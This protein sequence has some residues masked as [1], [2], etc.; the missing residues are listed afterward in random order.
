ME[1][2][3]LALCLRPGTDG[4]LACAVM[5]VLFRDGLADRDYLE[6]HTDAP[7]EFEAHLS[8][9]DPAWAS[10]ITGLTV[11]E[12]ETFARLVGE[13]KRTF[14]RL[15]YGF[16]RQRNGAVNMHAATCIAAVTGAWK[17]EGGGAF[18]NN[19]GIYKW[20]QTF[21]EGHDVRDRSVRVLDQCHIGRI[22]TGDA[23]SLDYGP[24]VTAMLIQNTNPMSVAPEQELWRE[25]SRARICSR[26]CTSIS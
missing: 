8:T 24:P 2:A 5:H 15:G 3:D 6:S 1:Q 18:H 17:Y 9:R 21:H 13:T 25:A 22:L 16:S 7:R 23:Q 4:A 14:F 20:S 26:S 19:G 10:R 11:E 12:I